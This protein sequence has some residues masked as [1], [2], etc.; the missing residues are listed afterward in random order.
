MGWY[1]RS[2]GGER[3]CL[4]I[5]ESDFDGVGTAEDTLVPHAG[6]DAVDDGSGT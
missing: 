5:V 6:S 4:R 2:G 1:V 3:R